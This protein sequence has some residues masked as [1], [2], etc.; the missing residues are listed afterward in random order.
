[1]SGKMD[2]VGNIRMACAVSTHPARLVLR[3]L[4]L[5]QPKQLAFGFST[6]IA[7]C[8]RRPAEGAIRKY[9]QSFDMKPMLD[10]RRRQFITLL[11]SGALTWPLA[12]RA[13]PAFG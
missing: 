3:A 6:F 5:H 7:G 4:F 9:T 1:S 8:I 12:T 2:I 13:L 10:Q 11:G